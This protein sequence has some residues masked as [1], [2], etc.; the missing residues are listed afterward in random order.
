MRFFDLLN[1]QHV[2]AYIFVGLLFLLV[3][4]VGLAFAHFRDE[5][6]ERRKNEIIG[7][8]PEE[9]QDRDAPF[10]LIMTLII[11]GTVIWGFFYILMHGLLGVK[12]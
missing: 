5:H 9:I 2:M 8:F 12:I 7:R 4:G 11:A 6:S 3:F 10:P 1:F